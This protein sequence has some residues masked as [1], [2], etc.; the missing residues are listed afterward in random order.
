[1]RCFTVCFT[2]LVCVHPLIFYSLV[3]NVF[4][5]RVSNI[6]KQY[7]FRNIIFFLKYKSVSNDDEK[8]AGTPILPESPLMGNYK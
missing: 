5:S 3:R 8:Q 6:I 7:N 4:H 2:P 1:M